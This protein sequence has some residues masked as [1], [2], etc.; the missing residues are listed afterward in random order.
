MTFGVYR[1]SNSFQ[2][3]AKFIGD[4]QKWLFISWSINNYHSLPNTSQE[5]RLG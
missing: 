1:E 3:F 4:A 2:D 5:A